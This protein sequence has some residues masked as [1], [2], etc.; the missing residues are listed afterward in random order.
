[1]YLERLR[2][3]WT[4]LLRE[5]ANEPLIFDLKTGKTFG[6]RLDYFEGGNLVVLYSCKR[7]HVRKSRWIDSDRRIED[8]YARFWLSEI[9][10][11]FHLPEE[12]R[13]SITELEDVLQIHIDPYFKPMMGIYCDWDG[14]KKHRP[15]CDSRLHEALASIK[16]CHFISS[17]KQD[18]RRARQ[19]DDSF[20]YVR[21][22]LIRYGAAIP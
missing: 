22:R 14:K 11:I 2:G 21:R 20:S 18:E 4:R 12:Q 16:I 5:M 7:L 1:M 13:E 9:M 10:E 3:H 15:E 8:G 6:G 19:F 17:S